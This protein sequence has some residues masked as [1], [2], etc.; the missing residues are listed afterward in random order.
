MKSKEQTGTIDEIACIMIHYS[1]NAEAD[2]LLGRL[3]TNRVNFLPGLARQTPMHMVLGTALAIMD[4]E[5]T[6]GDMGKIQALVRQ[7]ETG[8]LTTLDRLEDLYLHD[9]E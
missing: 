3:G 8:D 5:G 2:Y 1:G 4:H 9:P 7:V 6:F